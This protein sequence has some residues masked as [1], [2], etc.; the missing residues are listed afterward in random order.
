[1]INRI[2]SAIVETQIKAGLLKDEDRDIYNYGYMLVIETLL[3]ILVGIVIGL[4]FKAIDT[5]MIFWLLYIPLRIFCGGWHAEKSWQCLIASNVI[6]VFVIKAEI[7]MTPGTNTWV[8]VLLEILLALMLMILSP[9]PTKHKPI[10]AREKSR[11]KRNCI[12][13]IVIE[14]S[15]S[16]FIC[17]VRNIIMI[18]Y[19]VLLISLIMQ[20]IINR[21]TGWYK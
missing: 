7:M 14:L 3:N 18:A 12:E 9:V 6:L 16:L 13:I 8:V 15:A 5:I 17:R 2:T 20:M 4:V 19:S 10:T 1:M 21:K 11:F